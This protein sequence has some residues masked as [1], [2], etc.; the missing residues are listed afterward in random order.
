VIL[1]GFKHTPGVTPDLGAVKNV[2]D[3]YG[4]KNPHTGKP[5]SEA[6]L[7]GLGGGVG[8]IYFTFTFGGVATMYIGSRDVRTA[9]MPSYAQSAAERV[10]CRVT[11]KESAGTKTAEANLRTALDA[12]KPVIVWSDHASLPYSGLPP[13]KIK[14]FEHIFVVYGLEDGKAYVAD[15]S[16]VPHVITAEQLAFSRSQ[17]SSQKNRILFMDPPTAAPDLPS[18]IREGIESCVKGMLEPHISNFGLTGLQKL[19]D[20]LLDH[21]DKQGWPK[22]FLPAGEYLF[23]ALAWGYNFIEHYGTGGQGSRGLYADFLDEAAAILDESVLSAAATEYRQS[24][25]LW[26][27]MARGFLPDSVPA[28]KETRDLLDEDARLFAEWPE[29]TPERRSRNAEQRAAIRAAAIAGFPLSESD[30]LTLFEE[31]RER[32]LRVRAAEESAVRMLQT[33]VSE[34]AAV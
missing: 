15:R 20:R 23:D 32:V 27:D 16:P 31:Q 21:K 5:Y 19:A 17:I 10:G 22:L 29:G 25:A 18:G 4:V 7:F 11:V 26:S 14:N 8:V 13:E 28:L 34:A 1:P 3:H 9:A 12:D 30:V 6:M 33:G 2:L 24:G